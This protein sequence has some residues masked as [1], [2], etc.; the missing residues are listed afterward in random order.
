M[1]IVKKQDLWTQ[2]A[3]GVD[4]AEIGKHCYK[5][6][7]HDRECDGDTVTFQNFLKV[8][9]EFH[10]SAPENKGTDGSS[11]FDKTKPYEI[12]R[13]RDTL[14]ISYEQHREVAPA[15]ARLID[16]TNVLGRVTVTTCPGAPRFCRAFLG[17]GNQK[18]FIF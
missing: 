14:Q 17:I 1:T 4:A 2:P 3:V 15:V 10:Y 12:F 7:E 8:N 13:L 18:T 5:V 11:E 9:D 6:S 16:S